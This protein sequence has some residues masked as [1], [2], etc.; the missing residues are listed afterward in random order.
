M[1][2]AWAG[3]VLGCGSGPRAPALR[4][5]PVYQNEREGFRFLVPEGWKQHA[6]AEVPPRKYPKDILLVEYKHLVPGKGALLQVSLADLPK[7]TDLTT[8][9]AS[10]AFGVKDWKPT[11]G[12]EGL[13]VDGG[14]ATRLVFTGRL[15]PQEMTRE[16]V[17]FRRGERVY[18]FTGLYNTGDTESRDQV[19]RAVASTLWK[20]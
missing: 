19:R 1:M 7:G 12:M 8:F 15:G 3:L 14:P 6:K 13:Q 4:D 11:A 9:L 16:V 18:F 5:D 10:P 2:A 17:V 20:K